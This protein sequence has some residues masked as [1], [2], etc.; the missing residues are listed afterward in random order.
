MNLFDSVDMF[1][2]KHF[3]KFFIEINII[4]LNGEG[5]GGI[6]FNQQ[7]TE[8]GGGGGGGWG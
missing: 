1:M 3:S 6:H 5:G 7:H 4:V 8:M 2:S